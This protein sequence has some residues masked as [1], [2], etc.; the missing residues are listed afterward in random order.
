[1]KK[2]VINQK[3]IGAGFMFSCVIIFTR[4]FIYFYGSSYSPVSFQSQGLVLAFPVGQV[5]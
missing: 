1:M 5:Y 3:Y 4:D 2:G